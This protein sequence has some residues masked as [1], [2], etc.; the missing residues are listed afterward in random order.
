MYVNLVG[1]QDELVFDGES[2][3]IDAKGNLTSRAPAFE[4][5]V[6][7]TEFNVDENNE[8]TPVKSI[9]SK[10]RSELE[11]V[12]QAIVVGVRDYIQKNRFPGILVGLSGG[13]D[14]GLTRAPTICGISTLKGKAKTIGL[15]FYQT[16][17]YEPFVAIM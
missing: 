12:Y 10:T 4:E 6:F 7:V 17:F 1:G 9:V 14:S 15:A 11:T 8:V 13:I 2:F 3:V 5:G 16:T